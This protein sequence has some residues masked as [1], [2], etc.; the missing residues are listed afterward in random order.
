MKSGGLK[1][2]KTLCILFFIFPVL[3]GC[4]QT[5]R[6]SSDFTIPDVEKKIPFKVGLYMSPEYC[7]YSYEK[8]FGFI[9]VLGDALC[10]G[11]ERVVKTAFNEVVIISSPKSTS[12]DKTI[13]AIIIP[14]I[15]AAE[16]Q[17]SGKS[18]SEALL[19]GKWTVVDANGKL[20]W[21]DTFQGHIVTTGVIR[22]S[23]IQKRTQLVVEDYFQK[24]LKGISSW[25]L[26]ELMK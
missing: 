21:V 10:Y 5:Y 7:N 1:I 25:K 14:E 9:F 2:V 22:P 8:G 15:L 20:I 4:T 6:P 26:W 19:I 16:N 23:G 17:I 24:A 11:T 12:N 13:K 18:P 3:S